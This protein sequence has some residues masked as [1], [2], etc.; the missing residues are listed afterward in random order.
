MR[1]RMLTG[2]CLAARLGNPT[3]NS[4]SE[5]FP[6]CS[7]HLAL[8]P[9]S[10]PIRRGIR[11]IRSRMRKKGHPPLED[12][13]EFFGDGMSAA[14]QLEA[15]HPGYAPVSGLFS[16]AVQNRPCLLCLKEQTSLARPLT[17]AK[18]QTRTSI[19]LLLNYLVGASEQRWW[20]GQS[21]R[22]GGLEVDD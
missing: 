9:S 12:R 10:A 17:S 21:E 20:N 15:E 3:D 16:D 6:Y 8:L 4:L 5:A 19:P 13:F 1:E 2:R 14:L 22:L 18:C 11:S 7:M